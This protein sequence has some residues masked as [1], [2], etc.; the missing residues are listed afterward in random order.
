[1]VNDIICL[2]FRSI[3]DL[4]L[5]SRH[6]T[7]FSVPHG[8]M[9]QE[10]RWYYAH[11]YYQRTYQVIFIKGHNKSLEIDKLVKYPGTQLAGS[12]NRESVMERIYPYDGQNV[13]C[14]T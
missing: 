3:L 2:S 4:A 14:F 8:A 6:W 12:L 9:W 1:M 5:F 13:E 10:E 7:G 11:K